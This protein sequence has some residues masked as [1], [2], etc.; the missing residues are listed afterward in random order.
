MRLKFGFKKR[1]LFISLVLMCLASI[2]AIMFGW[3]LPVEKALNFLLMCVILLLAII[4]LAFL[5]AFLL[6]LI[7]RMLSS[8]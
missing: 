4:G 8:K 5:T 1:S 3:D 2:A 6:N 7:R